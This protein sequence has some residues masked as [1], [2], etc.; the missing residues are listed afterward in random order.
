M[1]ITE[2]HTAAGRRTFRCAVWD[3][4]AGK[5]IYKTFPTEAAAKSWGRAM[6]VK[7][8]S[9]EA[10]AVE[11]RTLAQAA[12]DWLA[13]ANAGTASNASGLPYKPSVLRGYEASL[14]KHVLPVLGRAKLAQIR[15]DM[16]QDMIDR[17][18]IA[19]QAAQSI[20]NHVTPL[21]VIFADARRQRL[22]THN[23]LDGIK[24]PSGGKARDRIAAPAE[25][26]KLIAALDRDR[27]LWATAF[28]TGLRRGELMA[29][30]WSCVDLVEREI[31]VTRSYDPAADEGERWVA[32]KSKAGTRT[33]PFPELLLPFLT[34]ENRTEGLVFGPDGETPFNASAVRK[35]AVTAW[36]A[37]GLDPITLHECRHTYA[38]LMLAAGVPMTLVSK[39]MGHSSITITV[40]RYGHLVPGSAKEHMERFEQYLR[41]DAA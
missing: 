17:M 20:R 11:T 38:S 6:E 39:W 29:L 15:I 41:A 35:R 1:T 19:G 4:A 21:R 32:P 25:A 18:V 26:V 28:Y 3:N 33:V 23:P 24:L 36:G 27:A 22:M 10:A 9:G 37:A 13:R 2:R 14:T 5:R 7:V 40:D 12:A 31:R 16:V 8:K 34:A 30:D